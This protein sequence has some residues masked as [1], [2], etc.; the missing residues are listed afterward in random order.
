MAAER[1]GHQWVLPKGMQ[2]AGDVEAFAAGETK[3]LWNPEQSAEA[4]SV[5]SRRLIERRIGDDSDNHNAVSYTRLLSHTNN[6]RH[7][8]G[9]GSVWYNN[10]LRD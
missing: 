7:G 8:C 2:S 3:H 5:D 1:P 4:K 6:S 10:T 9:S